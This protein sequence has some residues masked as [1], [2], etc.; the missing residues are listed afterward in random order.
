MEL[1]VLCRLRDDT[2]V[3]L[4]PAD[5]LE[6]ANQA[7]LAVQLDHQIITAVFEWFKQHPDALSATRKCAINLASATLSDPDFLRFIEQLLREYPHDSNRFCFEITESN[8]ID[9]VE[10]SRTNVQALRAHGFRVSNDDFGTGF[11]TYSY[12]KRY[13]VDEIKIDGTFVTALGDNAI[14]S[15]IVQ[16]IVRVAQMLKVKT[17][18]E[19]VAT[20]ELRARVERLGVDYVQG[21][22]IGIP[23]PIAKLY[24]SGHRSEI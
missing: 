18:A 19:F 21:F 14:D 23:Q 9:D 6:V 7:G 12:L 24:A 2:G 10:Q 15:E 17:V 1:E 20:D 8:A 22:A 11:A 16:S 5:F 4:A 13:Q 3:L